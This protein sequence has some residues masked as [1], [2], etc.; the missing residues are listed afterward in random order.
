MM[1]MATQKSKNLRGPRDHPMWPCGG[2]EKELSASEA[3]GLIGLQE[4]KDE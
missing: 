3:S 2:K 1:M 4:E